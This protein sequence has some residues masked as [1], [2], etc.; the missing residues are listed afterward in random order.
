MFHSYISFCYLA[1]DMYV[2]YIIDVVCVVYVDD[3]NDE[4]GSTGITD[5]ISFRP[6][7]TTPSLVPTVHSTL[8][9]FVIVWGEDSGNNV[10]R[11]QKC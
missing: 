4:D 3:E 8:F 6:L 11:R 9:L 2:T 1:I 10:G 5:Y 7:K